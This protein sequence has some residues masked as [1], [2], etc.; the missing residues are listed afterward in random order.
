[1]PRIARCRYAA[2]ITIITSLFCGLSANKSLVFQHFLAYLTYFCVSYCMDQLFFMTIWLMTSNYEFTYMVML[3]ITCKHAIDHV[4]LTQASQ[5]LWSQH[6]SPDSCQNRISTPVGSSSKLHYYIVVVLPHNHYYI[7][8]VTATLLLLYL[9]ART[10]CSTVD[11]SC[12]CVVL[13]R[14][15]NSCVPSVTPLQGLS[16]SLASLAWFL[17]ER[18]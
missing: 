8:V 15:I 2:H 18:T 16:R 10:A 12:A 7:R 4:M 5:C 13:V 6:G 3:L 1:M 9:T 17:Y 14:S 11:V